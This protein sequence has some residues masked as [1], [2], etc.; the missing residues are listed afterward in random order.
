MPQL[1]QGVSFSASKFFD[2]EVLVHLAGSKINFSPGNWDRFGVD[3]MFQGEHQHGT[4][5]SSEDCKKSMISSQLV[6]FL[7][8]GVE[9]TACHEPFSPGQVTVFVFH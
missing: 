8:R 7:G 9:I 4:A 1:V 2:E 6:G 5:L 3:G